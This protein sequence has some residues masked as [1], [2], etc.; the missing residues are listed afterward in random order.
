M[1]LKRIA[2]YKCDFTTKFGLPRQ[3][4][5]N[6]ELNALIVPDKEFRRAEAFYGIEQFTH[7][8][9][10]WGFK[11]QDRDTPQLTVRPPRLGGNER[12][13]VFASRSPFRPNPLGLTVVRLK[14]VN[15]DLSLTVSGGDL[16]DGTEIYDI[17][18][19]IP[20]ADRAEDAMGGFADRSSGYRLSVIFSNELEKRIPENKLDAL[21][22]AL[23]LDPRPAY[24]DDPNRV[25]GFEYAGLDVRFKV[26]GSVLTVTDIKIL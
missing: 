11:I 3:S 21:K 7:L 8:W 10:I 17:K 25:Y 20:Y 14:S 22:L 5:L 13:G 19:Y 15:D 16:M 24:Q 4:G 23:S 2:V 26:N 1:L 9:L 12:I 18:P 6:P